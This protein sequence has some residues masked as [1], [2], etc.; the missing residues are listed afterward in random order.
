MRGT[1]ASR[2]VHLVAG[3]PRSVFVPVPMSDAFARLSQE[4]FDNA[5]FPDTSTTVTAP[6]QQAATNCSTYH[7]TMGDTSADQYDRPQ[8]PSGAGG[9]IFEPDAGVDDL[10]SPSEIFRASG[11]ALASAVFDSLKAE[12][13]T[14]PDSA[15][16]YREACGHAAHRRASRR[17]AQRI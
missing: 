16:A 10:T 13:P 5:A 17:R 2:G 7:T 1:Y 9:R 8:A 14:L 12:H 6:A 3:H 4:A 11:E 15:H